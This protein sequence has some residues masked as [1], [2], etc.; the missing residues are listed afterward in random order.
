MVPSS[1]GTICLRPHLHLV[2]KLWLLDKCRNRVVL[3]G[4]IFKRI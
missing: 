1:I 2:P 3:R 4:T